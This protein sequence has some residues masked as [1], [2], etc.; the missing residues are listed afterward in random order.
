MTAI[1]LGTPSRAYEQ[2]VRQ[3][4][5]R[6]SGDRVVHVWQEGLESRPPA[7]AVHLLAQADPAIVVLGPNL[8]PDYLLAVAQEF[9]RAHPEVSVV[10][11]AAIPPQGLQAALRAGVRDVLDPAS[12]RSAIEDVIER[13]V[14]AADRRRANL[15]GGEDLKRG[16]LI[17]LLSPKGGT[18]KTTVATNLAVCLARS[19]LSEVALVDLDL[20]FGDVAVALGIDPEHTIAGA[21]GAGPLDMTEVKVWMSAHR[22]G[23]YALCSPQDPAVG[24][25]LTPAIIA[26]TL[27]LLTTAFDYVI[28][29][30][31]SGLDAAALTALE[32]SDDIVTVVSMDVPAVRSLRKALEALGRIGLTSARRHLVVNRANSRVGLDVSDVAA[33]LGLAITAVLPSSRTVPLAFNQGTPFASTDE[34]TALT[35]GIMQLASAFADIRVPRQTGFFWRR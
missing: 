27:D 16:R 1:V 9:D 18:G 26:Q 19:T 17:T 13:A 32:R 22:S 20:Q 2:R 6:Q 4:I 12:D 11:V 21:L 14:A 30:T 23:V 28:V 35:H 10:L 5:P 24:E 29:D 33:T 31:A 34:R 8:E 3:A 15:T 25:Q 7:E